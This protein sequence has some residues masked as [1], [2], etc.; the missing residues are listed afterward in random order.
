MNSESTKQRLIFLD[1]L[2]LLFAILVIFQHVRVTYG[3]SGWWYYIETASTDLFSYIFFTLVT[4]IGG[5][6]QSSLMGLFFL[7]GGYFTPRSYDRKGVSKF[8]KER[9]LR[10]GIP[11]LLYSV[12]FDPIIKYFLAIL[13]IQPWKDY[14]KFQ[15]TFIEYYLSHF[16][17]LQ[18]L[19]NFLTSSGPMWFLWVL[20]LLTTGYTLWR[21]LVK[22]GSLQQSIPEEFSIP[23]YFYLLL[24]AI[25]LG[26]VTFLIRIISS[27]DE[28]P[29]GIPLA[30][31]PQ[32]IM[33]FSVGVIAVRY[34][35]FEEMF[36]ETKHIKIWSITIAAT[37]VGFFAYYFLILG[38]EADLSVFL[39]GF[40]FH[41]LIF[42]LVDNIICMGMIF[43][44]ITIFH[45][46]FNTQG[47][48]LRDLSSSSYH[49][50]L[51]HAPILVTV[52]LVFAFIPLFPVFKLIIVFPITILLCYLASHFIL[53][54]VI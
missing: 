1:N 35:W 36:K 3:G 26:G 30:F 19:L 22:V 48:L 49:I 15:G 40:N 31:M 42:A 18:S 11:L 46:K 27:I 33:M 37:V 38:M 52:S 54:K 7:M 10:L 12:V 6:F 14:P 24:A 17:S 8:W 20:L 32:Y 5:L 47:V 29:L 21:Q 25:I 50:Y 41:A 53:Q 4:S 34:N 39:G 44:L 23:K 13:G 9:L 2:K 45:T 28:F 43:V 51:I 16:Q